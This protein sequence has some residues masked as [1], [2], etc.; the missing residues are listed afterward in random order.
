VEHFLVAVD[1]FHKR[2]NAAFI[3]KFRLFF[4]AFIHQGDFDAGVEK[5]QFPQAVGN[6]IK[7]EFGFFKNFIIRQKRDGGAA[8]PAFADNLQGPV[9]NAPLVGLPVNIPIASHFQ[10]TGAGKRINHRYADAVQSAGYLVGVVV[11]FS[12]GVQFGHG[13]FRSR[14]AFRFMKIHRNAPA[15]VFHDNAVINPDFHG[16][17]ITE[18]RRR[19]VNAVVNNFVNQMMKT[20]FACRTN[21]HGRTLAN[22]FQAF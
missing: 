3:E 19:F 20:F 5:R 9:R 2:N 22:R 11:K 6:H 12:S 10:F 4:R 13:D 15:V 17:G 14:H 7:A 21:I 8:S 18:P 1:V 16:N